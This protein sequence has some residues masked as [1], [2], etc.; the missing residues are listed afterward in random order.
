VPQ[1]LPVQNCQASDAGRFLTNYPEDETNGAGSAH[2]TWRSDVTGMDERHFSG[3]APV[4]MIAIF[5]LDERHFPAT[6]KG[7]EPLAGG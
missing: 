2:G 4:W 7:S 3:D 5:P 1:A 6:P